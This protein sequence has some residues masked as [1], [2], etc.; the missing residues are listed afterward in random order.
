MC[1]PASLLQAYR[2]PTMVQVELERVCLD[3]MTHDA[4]DAVARVGDLVARGG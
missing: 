1:Q 3:H 2:L 4:H